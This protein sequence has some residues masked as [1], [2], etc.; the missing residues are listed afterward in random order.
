M[1]SWLDKTTVPKETPESYRNGDKPYRPSTRF[2]ETDQQRKERIT[3][4]YNDAKK[5][6]KELFKQVQG[7]LDEVHL[8]KALWRTACQAEFEHVPSDSSDVPSD[9]SDKESSDSDKDDS[10]DRD[11]SEEYSGSDNED[12]EADNE[13]ELLEGDQQDEAPVDHNTY[14]HLKPR[15]KRQYPP[16]V[17]P[18][19]CNEITVQ[20]LWDQVSYFSQL[21]EK[22]AGSLEDYRE[23]TKR[24]T[25]QTKKK[26]K[27][28]ERDAE[29]ES[30]GDCPDLQENNRQL[31]E[32]NK[33][34]A[35]ENEHLEGELDTAERGN[36][37]LT[38]ENADLKQKLASLLKEM[39]EQENAHRLLAQ[40]FEI[41]SPVTNSD[42]HRMEI[43]AMPHNMMDELGRGKR[44]RKDQVRFGEWETM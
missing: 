21:A 41:A 40:P 17:L 44:K 24:L 23:A 19:N 6:L 8:Q 28:E 7:F 43:V 4:S 9:S 18:A 15:G 29:N 12:K 25:A 22:L 36:K 3:K 5:R 39:T 10:N 42:N 32:D 30:E 26:K 20:K 14:L 27:A 34:L 37:K 2:L 16:G 33:Q 31:A 38:A 13:G 11:F 35:E 1:N